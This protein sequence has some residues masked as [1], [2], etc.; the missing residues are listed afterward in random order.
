MLI[1]NVP[2]ADNL[3]M[4]TAGTYNAD[5]EKRQGRWVIT[6]WYIEADSPLASSP[7][8][9]GFTGEEFKWIPDPS[10]AMVSSDPLSRRRNAGIFG[11]L[12]TAETASHLVEF[13]HP[14]CHEHHDVGLRS[15]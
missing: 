3:Q 12:G 2:R 11:A 1:S 15:R 13:L 10:T 8:P 7:L 6:R 14:V 9:E 4:L 5:L